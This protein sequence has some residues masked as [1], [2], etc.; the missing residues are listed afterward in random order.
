[1]PI[2]IKVHFLNTTEERLIN[3]NNITLITPH[4]VDITS[5]G[6]TMPSYTTDID[7]TSGVSMRNVK[8]TPD[9][10]YAMIRNAVKDYTKAFGTQMLMCGWFK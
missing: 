5:C 2:F 9:E 1:M 7:F 4:R 3:V 8:E 6:V 10:I